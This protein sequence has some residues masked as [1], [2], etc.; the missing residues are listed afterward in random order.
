M[1]TAP[2]KQWWRMSG[3][4][5]GSFSNKLDFNEIPAKKLEGEIEF[6]N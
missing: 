2:L 3:V 5:Y 6:K 1:T 4:S